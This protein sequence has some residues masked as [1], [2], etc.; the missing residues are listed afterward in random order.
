MLRAGVVFSCSCPITHEQLMVRD[1]MP[2]TSFQQFG[3]EPTAQVKYT[4]EPKHKLA[5]PVSPSKK[6]LPTE[7]LAC[8]LLFWSRFF[9]MQRVSNL[10][11]TTALPC[12]L[13]WLHCCC[14]AVFPRRGTDV[15]TFRDETSGS[16]SATIA[17]EMHTAD[18]STLLPSVKGGVQNLAPRR[19]F[20]KPE[21]QV[22][23]K[24]P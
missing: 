11:K 14:K 15:A 16:W 4:F 5:G 12:N 19:N 24:R 13:H 23:R 22:M 1:T 17:S 20:T 8:Y 6:G 21:L 2:N 10:I 7:E 9:L 18:F 3:C